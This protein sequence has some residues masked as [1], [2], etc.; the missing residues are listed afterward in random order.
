[1]LVRTFLFTLSST[2]KFLRSS[3]R[4]S[5]RFTFT[6]RHL[7]FPDILAP[8][9]TSDRPFDTTGLATTC[10]VD[11]CL[12][13]KSHGRG[14]WFATSAGKLSKLPFSYIQIDP[15]CRPRREAT[16]NKWW[17]DNWN[18]EGARQKQCTR[19]YT[20]FF[21]FPNLILNHPVNAL[22]WNQNLGNYVHRFDNRYMV[23]TMSQINLG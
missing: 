18:F 2:P 6:P 4:S 7:F 17:N 12:E 19:K 21:H 11:R 9:P 10:R 13:S 20:P 15:S 23:Q 14:K 5:V 1:M 3:S 22:P 16:S 8:C